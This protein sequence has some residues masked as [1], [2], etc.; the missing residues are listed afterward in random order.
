MRGRHKP[1]VSQE[2]FDRV[3]DVLDDKKMKAVAKH[4][5][6]SAFPLKPFVRCEVW[7][8]PLTGGFARGKMGKRCPLYWCRKPGCRA[9]KLSRAALESQFLCLLCRLSPNPDTVSE[10]PK[11]AACVWASEIGDAEQ[12]A[13]KITAQIAK[14]KGLKSKLLEG[15]LEARIPQDDYQPAGADYT[16]QIP[17]LERQL[18]DVSS[19]TASA[20][21]LTRF[22]ELQL[23]DPAGLWHGQ[24]TIN[25]GEFKLFSSKPLWPILRKRRV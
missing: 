22:A 24:T 15:Y 6:N 8:T 11:I 10:F 7:G 9:V 16:R 23:A 17:E 25:V 1:I 19:I 20:D 2:L 21:A 14:V 3:Q 18:R 13:K 4:K 12:R 5:H